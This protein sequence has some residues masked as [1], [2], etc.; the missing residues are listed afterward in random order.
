[1]VEHTLN[2]RAKNRAKTGD[3]TCKIRPQFL[4]RHGSRPSHIEWLFFLAVPLI[5]RSCGMK[6]YLAL[7]GHKLLSVL[8]LF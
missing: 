1:V 7:L 5:Q 2:T 8:R 4:K 3:A 6:V